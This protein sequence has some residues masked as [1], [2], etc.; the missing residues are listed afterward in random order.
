MIDGSI[1]EIRTENLPDFTTH[2]QADKRRVFV[3]I[4][5]YVVNEPQHFVA[6][7]IN[8][9]ANLIKEGTGFVSTCAKYVFGDR[10]IR[11]P[12]PAQVFSSALSAFTGLNL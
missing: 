3:H 1:P 11:V 5:N 9:V 7:I 12:A 6:Q 2:A 4:D 10:N 8:A